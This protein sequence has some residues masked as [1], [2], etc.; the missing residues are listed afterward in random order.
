[1]HE[2]PHC[3]ESLVSSLTG[4]SVGDAFGQQYM[5]HVE[6]IEIRRE[7]VPTWR[8]TDDTEMAMS[9]A[10]VLFDYGEVHQDVLA[11][12]FADNF[13]STRGYGSAMLFE[14]LPKLQKGIHW[15]SLASSLFDGRGSY[16]NGAAMRV[17]PLG[18]CYSSDIDS[19]KHQSHLSAE[20][21][22]SH[23]EGIAGAVAVAVASAV[24]SRQ[25]SIKSV[26]GPRSFLQEV[27]GHVP[28]SEVRNRLEFAYN[29]FG[30]GIDRWSLIEKLGNGSHVTAQD[31]VPLCLW[32]AGKHLN[33]YE[34]ALYDT[35]AAL[36]DMD[37]NCAIVGGIVAANV[38]IQ[39][40]PTEWQRATEEWP[41]WFRPYL[42]RTGTSQ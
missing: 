12:R 3:L 8:W 37:T 17:A 40:I 25:K 15:R 1:M 36:G 32:M 5:W 31:T 38:G 26:S 28:E 27:I 10:S 24:A 29:E 41:A 33:N 42:K 21:T 30:P 9:V 18:A 11:S 23:S 34:E 13:D 22:H 2:R 19:V 6:D 4:L 20:V 16:G 7:D 35:V 14:F 39:G